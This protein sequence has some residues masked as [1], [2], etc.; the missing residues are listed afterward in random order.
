VPPAMRD[1]EL[2]P[3]L[4]EK[5]EHDNRRGD[6]RLGV[7]ARSAGDHRNP[8]LSTQAAAA[9]PRRRRSAHVS[10]AAVRLAR[11]ASAAVRRVLG[12]RAPRPRFNVSPA[13][14]V[15]VV[16]LAGACALVALLTVTEQPASSTR[17]PSI[18]RANSAIGFDR[19]RRRLLLSIEGAF[20]AVPMTAHP[21][22]PVTLT[23]ARRN[24]PAV[25]HG[26]RGATRRAP[27]RT[28]S[29]ATPVPQPTS[30]AARAPAV[31]DSPS[32]TQSTTSVDPAPRQQ[33]PM[34][35]TTQRQEIHYQ[36]PSQPSGPAGLGSQVGS[37]CNPKCS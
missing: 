7:D 5:P 25:H 31:T 36:Q 18:G 34:G 1:G 22:G 20:A 35:P 3:L 11:S 2:A 12:I 30:T 16:G 19:P 13:R 17:S 32:G 4:S 27:A 8:F 37:N 9:P 24:V 6:T 21:Y 28:T 10:A 33:A 15:A 14:V 23:E 29:H 26:R